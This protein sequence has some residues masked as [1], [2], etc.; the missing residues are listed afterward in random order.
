MC[1]GVP[2]RVIEVYETDGIRMGKIDFG[3]IVKEACLA[4][5]P[6]IEVDD[7]AIVHVG[8]AIT[9]LDEQSAQETLDLFNQIGL[10][11]EEFGE[12]DSEINAGNGVGVG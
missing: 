6:E 5:V 12:P 7:Y 3:G 10:L 11:E 1:L 4:Y 9:R 2:G 8:F